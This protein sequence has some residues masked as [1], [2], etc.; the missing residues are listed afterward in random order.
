MPDDRNIATP[1]IQITDYVTI[2]AEGV[3]G[4]VQG[5]PKVGAASSGTSTKD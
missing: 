3:S 1:H 2:P 5:T 4:A